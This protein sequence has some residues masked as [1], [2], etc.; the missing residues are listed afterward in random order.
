MSRI[1]IDGICF[2]LLAIITNEFAFYLTYSVIFIL[3]NYWLTERQLRVLG[4][5][6]FTK[7]LQK[8]YNLIIHCM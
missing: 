2:N 5:V 4:V 8:R 1:T 6:V 3:V 7:K